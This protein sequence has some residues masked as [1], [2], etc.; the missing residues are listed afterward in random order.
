MQEYSLK[1][2]SAIEDFLTTDDWKFDPADENG[3]IRFN[4]RLKCKF[5]NCSV[6]INVYKEAFIVLSAL[7]LM[8]DEESRGAVL[9]Y[10]N[11]ANYGMIHGSF[12]MNPGT[13]EI[14][15]R[16]SQ[17][18][19]NE[20]IMISEEIIRHAIYLNLT[21]IE[22]YGNPMLNV[23]LGHS[24]PAEAIAEAEET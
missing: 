2:A 3:K 9:D 17:Y 20:D 6:C 1:I 7:P 15:F 11:R 24:T 13:G 21:M 12:E 8:A 19:G 22:R 4:V 16:V 10:L 5:C 23:M 14:F 18:C